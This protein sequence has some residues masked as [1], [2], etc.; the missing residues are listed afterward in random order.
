MLD[1]NDKYRLASLLALIPIPPSYEGYEVA[2]IPYLVDNWLGQYR[3]STGT[4]EIVEVS[5]NTFRYLF[6]TIE[7]RLIAAWGVSEGKC[8]EPRP[9]TRMAGHP[10]ANGPLYHRGHAIPHTLG[11]GVDINLVPQLGSVNI[12]AFR[13][14]EKRAV[15]TPGSLYFT[16]WLYPPTNSQTPSNVEQGFLYPRQWVEI[17][18][19][20]N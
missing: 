17:K 14:L 12:G 1:E 20:S 8:T 9:A 13:K 11:G 2:I 7:D 15:A 10:L 19:H 3:S 6:D 5:Y 18:Q 4:S 16:H